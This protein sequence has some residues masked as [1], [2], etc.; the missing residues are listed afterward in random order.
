MDMLRHRLLVIATACAC[1]AVPAVALAAP[2]PPTTV[3]ATISTTKVTFGKTATIS[4]TTAANT[5]VTLRGDA[6]PFNN[7]F[8]R[9]ATTTSNAAGAYSFTVKPDASTH[10][11]TD[12]KKAQSQVVPLAVRWKVTR[13][14][15]T[16]RPKKG[17]RVLF[18][19][20]VS[21]V[22]NGGTASIQRRTGGVWKTVK[23]TTL[24]ASTATSS[25]YSV[26]VR[27]R[28]SGTYRVRVEGDGAHDAGNSSTVKLTIR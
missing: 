13:S 19:G 1:C 26:R 21:P 23:T 17:S 11:R 14:V 6:Y 3:T 2:K 25:A 24:A 18:S 8:G 16:K 9:V 5:T 7:S 28:R 12:V 4:G 22:H 10:Y 20:T 27:V 15:S